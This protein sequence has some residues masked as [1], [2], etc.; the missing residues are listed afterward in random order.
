[1]E[2]TYTHPGF[3]RTTQHCVFAWRGN[4]YIAATNQNKLEIIDAATM[5]LWYSHRIADDPVYDNAD[6]N[7]PEF[8]K[9]PIGYCI[10]FKNLLY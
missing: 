1:M 7:D 9:K 8:L 3:V 5:Q 6:F 10:F 2:G 4:A